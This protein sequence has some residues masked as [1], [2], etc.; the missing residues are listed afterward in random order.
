MSAQTQECAREILDVVPLVMRDIRTQMR[1]RRTPDLTVPQFRTLLFV[2]RNAGASLS[3]VADHMGLTLPSTSKLVDDL[4]KSGLMT[5]QEHA[6]DRRRVSLVVTQRGST[7]LEA[8]RK[9]TLSYLTKKLEG[10]SNAEAET[11]LQAMK[12]LRTVFHN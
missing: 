1:T 2:S 11:I 12:A 5:R 3:P 6:L 4:I 7:L 10:I 8:S 9:W